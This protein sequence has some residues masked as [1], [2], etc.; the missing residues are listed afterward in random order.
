M[1]DHLDQKTREA[2]AA[3]AHRLANRGDDEGQHPLDHQVF[4]Q[5]FMASMLGQGWRWIEAI[6]RPAAGPTV[7]AGDRGRNAA[8][9]LRA[10]MG[11]PPAT[12]PETSPS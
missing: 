1:S 6:A 7:P 11:W 12:G 9:A 3:L 5:E 10:E 2:V 8:A 4:A